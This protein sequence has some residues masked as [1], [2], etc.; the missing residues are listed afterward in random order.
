MEIREFFKIEKSKVILSVI[1]VIL[2]LLMAYLTVQS[3]VMCETGFACSINY[4]QIT[5]F[6]ILII[7]AGWPFLL[8]LG[9]EKLIFTRV[10]WIHAK[11]IPFLIIALV[12]AII[13]IY[14]LSCLLVFIY[15]KLRK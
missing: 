15:R 12:L 8:M 9:V 4:A 11:D 13:Y 3:Q 2:S 10:D 7:L 6:I 5:F 14:F 1:L